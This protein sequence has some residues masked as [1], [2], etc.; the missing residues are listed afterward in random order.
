MAKTTATMGTN[1]IMVENESAAADLMIRVSVKARIASKM[2]LKTF[3][4]KNN[5][6]ERSS[7]LICQMS[8]L[9]NLTILFKDICIL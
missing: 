6:L 5:G 9:K 4:R 7:R 2:V 1:A 8:Y 3:T